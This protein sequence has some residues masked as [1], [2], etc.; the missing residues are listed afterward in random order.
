MKTESTVLPSPFVGVRECADYLCMSTE[1]VY[2]HADPNLTKDF[3]PHLRMGWK[4]KFKLDSPEM[5]AWIRRQMK[6]PPR[7]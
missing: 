5:Q 1:Y 4:L 2:R 7:S 6:V 3:I